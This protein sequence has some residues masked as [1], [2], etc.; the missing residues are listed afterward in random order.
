MVLFYVVFLQLRSAKSV[1]NRGQNLLME[2]P[3]PAT[4]SVNFAVLLDVIL[5]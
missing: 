4:V 1:R 3:N 2:S 5:Y